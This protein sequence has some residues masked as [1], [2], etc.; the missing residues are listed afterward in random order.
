[1]NSIKSFI[2]IGLCTAIS[3]TIYGCNNQP[4]SNTLGSNPAISSPK[5][6]TQAT[7]PV[8]SELPTETVSQ[9]SQ[10][11]NRDPVETLATPEASTPVEFRFFLRKGLEQVAREQGEA[12]V[13]QRDP[14]ITRVLRLPC[15]AGAMAKVS[16][17]PSLTGEDSLSPDK[18]IEVDEQNNTLQR[19]AKPVDSRVRAISDNRILITAENN[20]SYWIDSAGNITTHTA[21]LSLPSPEN[22]P[23]VKHPE[24]A[25]SGVYSQRFRDLSSG[26]DRRIIS[27]AAC[28]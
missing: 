25:A 19:W 3:L 17:M 24:F 8:T 9:D 28:T 1:M 21:T 22:V 26:R 18:V 15:G 14:R 16:T 4:S 10:T 12:A 27:E 5:P 23:Y 20:Q 7:E 2:T 11:A 6:S 13:I